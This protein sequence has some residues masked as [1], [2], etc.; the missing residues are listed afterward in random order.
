MAGT[1]RELAVALAFVSRRL[2]ARFLEKLP[3]VGLTPTEWLALMWLAELG[4][5]IGQGLLAERIEADAAT[6]TRTIDALV[7]HGAVDRQVSTTD[8]RVKIVAL[9]PKADALIEQGEAI[10]RKIRE[11]I[12]RGIPDEE[13]QA[14][15]K[16]LRVLGDR[17]N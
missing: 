16:T 6:M 1:H 13:I 12:F 8:R 10:G 5:K 17:L 4:G 14:C 7:R 11:D 2:R 9:T 3:K 15:L